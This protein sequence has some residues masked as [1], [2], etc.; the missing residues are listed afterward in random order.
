MNTE[1]RRTLSLLPTDASERDLWREVLGPYAW[2]DGEFGMICTEAA[3]REFCAA[4]ETKSE[5]T[6]E[7]R[8]ATKLYAILLTTGRYTDICLDAGITP[9]CIACGR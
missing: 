4:A 1:I 8:Q 7:I 3:F 9:R 6:S 2:A 5:L